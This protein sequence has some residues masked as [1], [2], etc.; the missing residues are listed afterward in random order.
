MDIITIEPEIIA[1]LIGAVAGVAASL[2][3]QAAS[4][5]KNDADATKAISEAAET[6]IAPLNKRIDDQE[7]EI[8]GLKK[9]V[10][11][12]VGGVR[13]LIQ[14]IECLGHT[15]VW[16]PPADIDVAVPEKHE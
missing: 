15:P 13:K 11:L 6:L 12:Y 14:Q 7:I 3:T 9:L 4:R 1:A 2:V 10:G 8:R 16:T 5:K